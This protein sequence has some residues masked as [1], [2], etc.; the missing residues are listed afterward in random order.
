MGI[1]FSEMW[2]KIWSCPFNKIILNVVFKMA[3]ILFWCGRCSLQ[4]HHNGRD[5][6]SNHLPRDCLLN[7][8]FKAQIKENIKAPR[9]WPLWG[10]FT[11]YR[12]IPRTK[13]PW[14]G[15]CFHL[16]TSSCFHCFL[17]FA[18]SRGTPGA[19]APDLSVPGTPCCVKPWV[20]AR[21]HQ[22]VGASVGP[23]TLSTPGGTQRM[24][25]G[26]NV[27]LDHTPD[28]KDWYQLDIDSTRKCW[29]NI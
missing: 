11:G 6:V 29:I 28:S 13:G 16:M 22:L 10:E 24:L 14:R 17:T 19:C 27:S 9:H 25:N 7:R 4:W 20:S 3:A 18:A 23:W 2:I 21:P 15:K 26:N 1:N 12:W 8:V 5:G